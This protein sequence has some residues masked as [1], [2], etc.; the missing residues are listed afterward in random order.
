MAD[1]NHPTFSELARVNLLRPFVLKTILNQVVD[2]IPVEPDLFSQLESQ[3]HQANGLTDAS[4][5]AAFRRRLGWSHEV[6]RWQVELPYRINKYSQEHFS[7]KVESRFLE[8]KNKLDQVSYSL[9]RLR[10]GALAKEF[11]FRILEEEAS[12][13]ELASNHSEG[14]E[15]NSNGIVGPLPLSQGHPLLVQRL[16]S[17]TPGTLIPPFQI[18]QFWVVLRLES[19]VAASLDD[20]TRQR[21]VQ[22]LFDEWL[23]AETTSK[24]DSLGI[25]TNLLQ[26]KP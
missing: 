4:A 9:L 14:N 23:Q 11:Y 7:A 16:R 5:V 12:F 1:S 26:D 2:R 17:T 21:M 22:E 8:Q 13:A 24:I 3:F 18:D 25:E 19:Y 15:R 10:D 6:Y 20:A